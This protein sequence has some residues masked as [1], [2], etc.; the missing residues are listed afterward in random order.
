MDL[1]IAGRKALVF[2]G[3]RGMGR[4]IALQLAREGA[5]VT[6]AARNPETL[7]RAATELTGAAGATVH[8]V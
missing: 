2:G 5:A 6:I 4:A 8:A 3:S 7:A 1:G